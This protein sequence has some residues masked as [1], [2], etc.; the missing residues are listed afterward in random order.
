MVNKPSISLITATLNSAAELPLLLA[1]LSQQTDRD[2]EV[3]IVDG[4]SVDSTGSIAKL[5]DDV[6]TRF[7]CEPDNGLYDA[8]NKG[9]RAATGAFY[10]IAGADD[11]L[12]PNAIA[13]YKHFLASSGADVVVAGVRVGNRLRRGFQR[14][15]AWLGHSAMITSHSVGMLFRRSLH[16]RF[17]YY[18][19][20]YPIQA[21]GLF[22][23]RTCTADDVTVKAA[24]FIAGEFGMHGASNRDVVRT[25]CE[26][27]Q[28]QRE[29]GENRLIQYLLFQIRLIK[30]LPQILG[31]NDSLG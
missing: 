14:R 26:S 24:D 3:I 4:G 13:D 22:I 21:D 20:R 6:I 11:L 7:I 10:L 12:Y 17:G 2:F 29:T 30:Y 15:R 8:I 5:H 31:N 23:K 25:L 19:L 9:V 16:E 18:S 1:S 27:W 28:I